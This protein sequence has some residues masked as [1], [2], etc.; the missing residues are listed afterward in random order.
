MTYPSKRTL[1]FTNMFSLSL[2]SF[3]MLQSTV[4]WNSK[5]KASR[6]FELGS[7]HSGICCEKIRG[8]IRQASEVLTVAVQIDCGRATLVVFPTWLE[9]RGSFIGFPICFPETIWLQ[10]GVTPIWLA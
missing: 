6:D 1:P 2:C 10:K 4:V 7:A 5:K 3:C 8:R 9:T